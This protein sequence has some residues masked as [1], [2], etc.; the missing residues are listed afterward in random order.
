MGMNAELVIN[1]AIQFEKVGMKFYKDIQ[2]HFPADSNEAKTIEY[3]KREEAAHLKYFE[4][5]Y[6]DLRA[7]KRIFLQLGPAQ[8]E[9]IE[10][11]ISQKFFAEK[12]KVRE[13]LLHGANIIDILLF[14]A[15]MEMDAITYYKQME[16]MLPYA[17]KK[18]LHRILKEEGAHLQVILELIYRIKN[19]TQNDMI[20]I[21]GLDISKEL[22]SKTITNYRDAEF[23]DLSL[24]NTTLKTIIDNSDTDAAS[25]IREALLPFLSELDPELWML[26]FYDTDKDYCRLSDFHSRNPSVTFEN[27]LLPVSNLLINQA[28]ARKEI[29]VIQDPSRNASIAGTSDIRQAKEFVK[30]FRNIIIIPFEGIGAIEI[31]NTKGDFDPNKVN[32]EFT[33]VLANIIRL[34][35]IEREGMNR[36]NEFYKFFTFS[37]TD[38]TIEEIYRKALALIA[39]EIQASYASIFHLTSNKQKLMLMYGANY[40][41]QDAQFIPVAIEKTYMMDM[42]KTG[43]GFTSHEKN[44]DRRKFEVSILERLAADTV[45]NFLAMPIMLEEEPVGEIILFNK[46]GSFRRRDIDFME[47][48]TKELAA[49]LVKRRQVKQILQIQQEGQYLSRYFSPNLLKRL[50]RGE[51][52]DKEGI[53]EEI[54]VLF[55][56]IRGFTPMSERMKPQDIIRM[57]NTYFGKIVNIVLQNDG[58]IDKFIGDAIFVYWGVPIKHKNDTLL[59]TLTGIAIQ[60][61]VAFMKEKG[62]L[63]PDFHIGIGIN[64]GPAILGNIGSEERLEF[65][66]IGDTVNT[67]SRLCGIALKDQILVSG[68]VY[69]DI[70]FDLEV[71]PHGRQ[72]L[73]GKSQETLVYKVMSLKNHFFEIYKKAF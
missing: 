45:T 16:Q 42:I 73:K 19:Y 23:Q 66:A 38:V 44:L 4:D 57:L 17:E 67:A 33:A 60:E 32:R 18:I 54:T 21:D 34:I 51:L 41:F 46:I 47:F 39:K 5:I 7:Q 31:I 64:K 2:R 30:E 49:I 27:S 8:A 13:T 55:A 43:V 9:K 63:P 61:E 69:K 53:T 58:V 14:A 35:S 1:M 71:A 24:L 72:A 59:A 50:K 22:S 37:G 52:M 25:L 15:R 36:F 48:M 3:L 56:D 12:E 29:L 20:P 26:Y 40:R 68:S 70:F 6:N 65:T 11:F 62:I 10:R 28:L